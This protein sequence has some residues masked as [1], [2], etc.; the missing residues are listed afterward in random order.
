MNFIFETK[1]KKIEYN[2]SKMYF[3][4]FTLLFFIACILLQNILCASM[5]ND[6][7]HEEDGQFQMRQLAG[8]LNQDNSKGHGG[9]GTDLLGII[10][11]EKKLFLV[12]KS[13]DERTDSIIHYTSPNLT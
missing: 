6:Q 11:E 3:T 1:Q 8:I 13:L 9:H 12:L 4:K 2:L 5:Q 10:F 7:A